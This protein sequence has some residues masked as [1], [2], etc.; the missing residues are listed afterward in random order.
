VKHT[1]VAAEARLRVVV[2][3]SAGAGDGAWQAAARLHG[4]VAV[5][6]AAAQAIGP[7]VL[8]HDLRHWGLD[9]LVGVLERH[10]GGG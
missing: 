10:G 2:E 3:S 5:V 7:L 4:D 6:E 9:I 1:W 8:A